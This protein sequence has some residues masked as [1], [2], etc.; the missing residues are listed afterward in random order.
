MLPMCVTPFTHDYTTISGVIILYMSM[1]MLMIGSLTD[2]L[3]G[4]RQFFLQG[5]AQFN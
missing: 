1:I 5:G 2:S 4:N 3:I